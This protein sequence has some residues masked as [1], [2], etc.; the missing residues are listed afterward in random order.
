MLQKFRLGFTTLEIKA[1]HHALSISGTIPEWLN[2]V[3]VRNG[4]GKFE[5]GSQQLH[6]WFDGYSLL[7]RF[8]FSAGK[9]SYS[10]DFLNSPDYLTSLEMGAINYAA[11]SVDLPAMGHK[12]PAEST[13]HS[14]TN[15]NVNVTKI[16]DKYV[17]LTETP[18]PVEFDPFT[19]QT[20]GVFHFSDNLGGQL[21]TAHPHY[22]FKRN[23]QI[24]FTTQLG[25]RSMYNFYYLE[26]NSTQRKLIGSLPVREPAYAHSFA[27]TENYIILAEF[28]LLITPLEIV[29]SGKPLMDNF[30]WKPEQGTRIWVINKRDGSVAR[31][32]QAEA[33]FAFHH[34]NAFEVGNDLFMDLAA[35]DDA[36]IL[37][38]LYLSKLKQITGQ[39]TCGEVRRY[40]LGGNSTSVEYEVLSDQFVELPRLNYAGYSTKPYRYLYGLSSPNNKLEGFY[41]QLVKIDV[42]QQNSRAWKAEDCYPGEPVFVAAPGAKQED[43]GIILSV[44][45]DGANDCSFLLILRAT[46]FEEFGRVNLNHHIPFGFHGEFFEKATN[47]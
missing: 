4:P 9:V 3:L 7:T 22:D 35:Y 37:R 2:G 25:M 5:V 40:R 36:G 43:E 12:N 38:E 32:Y 20:K 15:A 34:I 11:F 18:Y 47:S 39:L 6:H 24:N 29:T 28:P 26:D 19:L 8:S 1:Y 44:V 17:A 23:A 30:K 31:N 10:C 14:S 13:K 21:T 41:N 27:V 33:F 42:Q 46:T 45:L 16:G